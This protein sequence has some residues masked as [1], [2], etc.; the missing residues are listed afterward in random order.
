MKSSKIVIAKEL[1][2]FEKKFND[3]IEKT[4]LPEEIISYI[5]KSQGKRLRPILTILITKIFTNKIDIFTYR[6]AILVELIHF[7]SLLHDDV[8]DDAK[9]RRK[10]KTINILYDDKTAILLGDYLFSFALK[11]ASEYHYD[12]LINVMANAIKDLS[13]G[14]LLELEI[15]KNNNFDEN[16]YIETI[17]LKTASLISSCFEIACYTSKIDK[18]KSQKIKQIGINF[19]LFFQIVDDI[20]D[21]VGTDTG[22]TVGI[23]VKNCKITLPIILALKNMSPTVQ[24]NFK[25]L[26]T[27]S[28]TDDICEKITDTVI[29]YKG[30]EESKLRAAQLLTSIISDME[31]YFPKNSNR[32]F[33]ISTILNYS[34]RS[35]INPIK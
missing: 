7:S 27:E 6:S 3:T 25:K 33:L 34:S 20:L 18:T 12:Y 26:W 16:K 32:D 8:I 10:N 35:N 9:F 22:K 24:N 31:L 29:S 5:K 2:L 13:L 23:D 15:S 28:R 17:K 1:S 19:G 30:I 14:E 11:S 21:Y 4:E